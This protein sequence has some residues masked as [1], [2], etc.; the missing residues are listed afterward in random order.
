MLRFSH[1]WPKGASWNYASHLKNFRYQPW[2]FV[3][4]TDAEAEAPILWPPASKSWPIGKDPDAGKDW[5]QEEKA[6]KEHE[7]V[8]WH[9]WLNGHEFEPTLGTSLVAQMVKH[10]PTMRETWVWSLGQ[11][12]PLG[13]EM[14]THSSTLAWK[15][16]QT[17]EPGK[18]QSM[19]SQRVRHGW[20]TSLTHW[21]TVR[22][23]E[24]YEAGVHEAA[25]NWTQISD[26][27]TGYSL[28]LTLFSGL[29]R[30]DSVFVCI[31]KWSQQ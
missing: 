3:G 22:G 29:Q 10:L 13:K 28:R 4:R 25:K 9:H 24:A 31:A 1:L 6:V 12:Y 8:V 18:L 30:K 21:E 16:P 19:G 26:E 27:T 11:E 14:A 23:R 20:V 2:I 15:I 7:M 5:R 17:E